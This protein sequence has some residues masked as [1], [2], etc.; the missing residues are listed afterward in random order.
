MKLTLKSL[1]LLLIV[2]S[3]ISCADDDSN[4][5]D[6][7]NYFPLVI[8]N[9][10]DY[11]NSITVNGNTQN[12]GETLMISGSTGTEP[13]RFS[14]QQSNIELPGTTTSVIS[15][16]EIYKEN[17]QNIVLDSNLEFNTDMIDLSLPIENVTVYNANTNEGDQFFTETGEIEQNVNGFPVT[18]NYEIASI[19]GGFVPSMNIEGETY[20][21]IYIS[22]LEV[23]M[24]ISVFLVFSEFTILAD[25]NVTTVTNYFAKDIGLIKSMVSTELIFED[26]PDQVGF[27]LEDISSTSTQNIID[28]QVE[29]DL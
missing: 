5:I 3:L 8:G 19:N 27:E 7:T 24:S 6:N 13:E 12:G 22:E 2:N 4:E 21:N 20:N 25:Q 17:G 26:I 9:S 18:I 15:A 1:L 23:N 11:Q 28:Y 14:F 29:L 10:W 16:G